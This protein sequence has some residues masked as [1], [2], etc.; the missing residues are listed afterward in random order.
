MKYE[1][2]HLIKANTAEYMP[3]E[4]LEFIDERTKNPEYSCQNLK[5]MSTPWSIDVFSLGVIL[6]E[7]A[8][9]YPVWMVKKCKSTTYTGRSLIGV[10]VFGVQNRS[11]KKI[12]K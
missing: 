4:V 3:P 1:D 9:G 8:T 2:L 12:A 7:I 6:L 11:M 10:G 5:E